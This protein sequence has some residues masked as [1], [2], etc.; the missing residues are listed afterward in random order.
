[1]KYDLIVPQSLCNTVG[2]RRAEADPLHAP[3]QFSKLFLSTPAFVEEAKTKEGLAML[4][5]F[6]RST[7]MV[8]ANGQ[9]IKKSSI[10]EH[11]ELEDHVQLGQVNGVGRREMGMSRL[12]YAE[13][14]DDL[15]RIAEHNAKFQKRILLRDAGKLGTEKVSKRGGNS[16]RGD[17]EDF[18]ERH[19]LLSNKELHA[20]YQKTLVKKVT[21]R[22]ASNWYNRICD[23][24]DIPHDM[25]TVS[26][27]GER[28]VKAYYVWSHLQKRADEVR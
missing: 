6:V 24:D 21:M 16:K 19:R 3:V 7:C 25:R 1:M 12:K 23:G 5:R 11:Y 22:E 27:G 8:D 15:L 18:K 2:L 17:F 10:W 20:V 4:R 28:K 9:K 13:I 14:S 26:V